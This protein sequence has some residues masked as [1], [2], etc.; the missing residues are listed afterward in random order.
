M[1][2]EL[3]NVRN[4]LHEARFS[5]AD[6]AELGLQLI[7]RFD[8]STIKA[9]HGQAN[10]CMIETISQWLKMDHEASWEKLAEAVVKVG[11]YGEATAVIVRK[12]A[13]ILHTCMFYACLMIIYF[14]KCQSIGRKFDC[15]QFLT[16]GKAVTLETQSP[17][18]C[19]VD[20]QSKP[21]NLQCSCSV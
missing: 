17:A 2:L 12:K 14:V 4:V 11:G 5:D 16:A 10:L 8:L 6:W 1:E 3:R 20:R 18:A 21:Y 7:D 19:T 13:E 9:D 15:S